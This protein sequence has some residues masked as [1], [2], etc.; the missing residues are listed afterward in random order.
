M[1]WV[2]SDG[3]KLVAVSPDGKV[4]AEAQPVPSPIALAARDGV[5]AVASLQTG[6]VHL[7]DASNPA[8]LKPLRTLGRGDGPDGRVLSERFFFQDNPGLGTDL[9]LGPHQELAVADGWR[10]QVFEPDGKVRWS[11]W[12]LWGG[13]N[14][15]SKA[16]PGRIYDDWGFTYLLDGTKGTWAPES[17]HRALAGTVIGD[18]RISGQTFVLLWGER[19][20]EQPSRQTKAFWKETFIRFTPEQAVPV[21]SIET[22]AG[23]VGQ[24]QQ[25]RDTRGTGHID[26]SD[27]PEPVFDIQGKPLPNMQAFHHMYNTV[28]PDGTLLCCQCYPPGSWLAQWKCAGLDAKGV[29]IYRWQD[30]VGLPGTDQFTSPFNW[31]HDSVGVG[32][33]EPRPGGGWFVCANI[34]SSPQAGKSVFNN[35]G[36]DVIGVDKAGNE[37]WV[38][39]CV[40]MAHI[41]GFAS[42]NGL[43]L[44][45]EVT[46]HD[47]H[48][49]NSDGLALPGFSS[50]SAD[51]DHPQA[52]ESFVDQ[53]GKVNVLITDCTKSCND[54]YR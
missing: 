6:K 8:T 2:I 11:C 12:G 32:Q 15:T 39:P 9:A 51:L 14:V 13:G 1:V 33:L 10:M 27:T 41:G 49:M 35:G 20:W 25:R 45:G 44:A 46:T 30:R 42:G 47:F 31:K 3:E 5:L 23:G 16:Q 17:Y 52:T 19:P 28:E 38:H 34:A 37:Q 18:C 53:A 24:L 21:L 36:T 40:Q 48:V 50:D 26:E 43:C 54:W 4:V 7:F 22:T 29:P